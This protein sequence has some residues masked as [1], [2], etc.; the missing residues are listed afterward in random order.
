ML[1]DTIATLLSVEHSDI[2]CK[3]VHSTKSSV[4]ALQYLY[5]PITRD[6]DNAY[7]LYHPKY[8]PVKCSKFRHVNIDG[9]KYYLLNFY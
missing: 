5:S 9:A 3:L 2:M 1:L 6:V 7:V 8:S 4:F